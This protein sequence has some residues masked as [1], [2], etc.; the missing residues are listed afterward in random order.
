MH[1]QDDSSE[2][3]KAVEKKYLLGNNEKSYYNFDPIFMGD[4]NEY[5]FKLRIN[6]EERHNFFAQIN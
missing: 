5:N 2:N 4:F 3:T 1:P 6:D